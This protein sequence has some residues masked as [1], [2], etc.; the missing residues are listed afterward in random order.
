MNSKERVMRTLDF[1]RP[2][3]IPIGRQS[4]WPEFVEKWRQKKKLSKEV[5]INDWYESDISIVTPDETFFPS[6]KRILKKQELKR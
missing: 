5:D 1:Q 6:Q 2:D 3:R 4:F